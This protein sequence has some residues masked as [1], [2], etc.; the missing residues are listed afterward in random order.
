MFVSN[1]ILWDPCDDSLEA[2]PFGLPGAVGAHLWPSAQLSAAY[3]RRRYAF[4]G[5]N[6]IRALELGSGCGVVGLVA[7]AHG[8][9]VTK[10]EYK[11]TTQT[12]EFGRLFRFSSTGVVPNGWCLRGVFPQKHHP[13]LGF[14]QQPNWTWW[15]WHWGDTVGWGCTCL[16]TLAFQLLWLLSKEWKNS[17]LG[18]DQ[19]WLCQ[20]TGVGEVK[21]YKRLWIFKAQTNLGG[22]KYFL[23]SPLLGEMIQFDYNIFFKWVEITS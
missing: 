23:F 7:A 10:Q 14:N 4:D 13:F 8:A 16:A 18:G 2:L 5:F 11:E 21:G 6:S 12:W 19:T 17:Q 15:P 20:W 9:E 3:L 22:F 1:I